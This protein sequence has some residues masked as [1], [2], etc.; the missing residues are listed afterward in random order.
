MA[1][2]PVTL[3]QAARHQAAALPG[4][5]AEIDADV[6]RDGCR[7][8]RQEDDRYTAHHRRETNAAGDRRCRQG[9]VFGRLSKLAIS[10]SRL[11]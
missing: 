10:C 8:R 11:S 2:G 5:L 3:D 6:L 1:L 4:A 9:F 7:R